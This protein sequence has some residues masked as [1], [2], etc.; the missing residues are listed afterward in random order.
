MIPNQAPTNI[1][2]HHIRVYHNTPSQMESSNPKYLAWTTQKEL[3]MS[4]CLNEFVSQLKISG[5]MLRNNVMVLY[6]ITYKRQS[7]STCLVHL[8][9][10][11]LAAF[12]EADYFSHN[13]KEQAE[14]DVPEN[15]Q[16]N[17]SS[18]QFTGGI[19]HQSALHR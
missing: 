5:Y 8:W 9:N 16:L 19:C 18:N 3:M 11:R 1:S 2:N 15:V 12:C 7:T 6:T 17:A 4:R 14:T 13:N 10:T